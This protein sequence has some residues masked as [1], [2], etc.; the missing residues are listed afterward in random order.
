MAEYMYECINRQGEIVRGKI[1]ADDDSSAVEKLKKMNLMIVELKLTDEAIKKRSGIF[2]K[3]VSIGELAMFSRQMAAMLNVGIP[4]T[5]ALIT[6]SQQVTNS[7]LKDA[8]A[9]ISENVESGRNLTDAF[10]MYPKIFPKI[11]IAMLRSGEVSGSLDEVLTRLS[12]QLQKEKALADNIKASTFYPRMVAGFAI[13]L[14]IV[15]LIF[16]VPVFQGFIPANVT[17]P[18]ITAFIFSLS[19]S[20]RGKWYIWLSIIA[21]IILVI[22]LFV[23]SPV[24][25]RLW[26]EIKFKIP[27]F[28]PI[29]HKSVL[30]RFSRTLSTLLEGGIPLIQALESAGP[31]SGSLLISEV[32]AEAAKQIEQGKNIHE[33]LKESKLFPPMMTQMIAIG[34]ETGS[35]SNML[36]KLAEFY[37]DEVATLTK[38]ITALIEPIMLVIVGLVIGAMI[39]ALYMP[40]FTAITQSGF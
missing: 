9:N 36:D 30:A 14:F 17:L 35:L 26:E 38:G 21:G 18:S 40:I 2:Q 20:I 32:A 5:R 23:K 6:I 1:L 12:D 27:A 4:V 29:L 25:K 10:N 16:M 37:E 13:L 34:E 7:T 11:Y 39:I 15:M 3:K 22:M 33:Q 24:G 19:E 8:L 28:G 31:T